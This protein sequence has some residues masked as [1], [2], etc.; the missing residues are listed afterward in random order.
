MP[1]WHEVDCE[2]PVGAKQVSPGSCEFRSLRQLSCE[3]LDIKSDFCFS[4]TINLACPA[5]T[6]TL[7]TNA[8]TK[9]TPISDVKTGTACKDTAKQAEA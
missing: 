9:A 4:V 5:T 8:R 1:E 3:M 2:L 7:L 6:P